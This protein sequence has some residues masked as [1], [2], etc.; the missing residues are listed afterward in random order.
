MSLN[1]HSVGIHFVEIITGIEEIPAGDP[2]LSEEEE[3]PLADI[4]FR[5]R[6]EDGLIRPIGSAH[7]PY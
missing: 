5:V 1:L 7:R 3:Q 6:S 4:P 2:A